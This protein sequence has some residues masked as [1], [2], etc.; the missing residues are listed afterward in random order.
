MKKKN[1]IKKDILIESIFMI[2]LVITMPLV[3]SALEPE[4]KGNEIKQNSIIDSISNFLK[5]IFSFFNLP[6]VS[7]EDIGC[8]KGT[9]SDPCRITT[10]HDCKFFN[11]IS[12]PNMPWLQEVFCD[13]HRPDN[14]CEPICCYDD[15]EGYC[16]QQVNRWVCLE[17]GRREVGPPD[18]SGVSLCTKGCCTFTSGLTEYDTESE[19][20]D[21]QGTWDPSVSEADCSIQGSIYNEGCC[22][23]GGLCT[24]TK[25]NE[26]PADFFHKD[27]FCSSLKQYCNCEKAQKKGCYDD[28]TDV[29]S[30]D[31][32]GNPED[33]APGG[34]CD[35]L[36]TGKKCINGA[37]SDGNCHVDLPNGTKDFT[38]KNGES[39]C[40]YDQKLSDVMED[41]MLDTKELS[42]GNFSLDAAGSR[43][44]RWYCENGEFHTEPCA[45]YRQEVCVQGTYE[46]TIN[47]ESY[48]LNEAQCVANPYDICFEKTT[49]SDCYA[50][51]ALGLCYWFEDV[52]EVSDLISNMRQEGLITA[53]I[54][55]EMKINYP[56]EKFAGF[57]TEE[58]DEEYIYPRCLPKYSPGY[59]QETKSPLCFLGSWA[60]A[61]DESRPGEF[62]LWTCG[63]NCEVGAYGIGHDDRWAVRE[64]DWLGLMTRRCSALGDCGLKVNIQGKATETN[65]RSTIE[66]IINKTTGLIA[67]RYVPVCTE[68]YEENKSCKTF[69][70]NKEVNLLKLYSGIADTSKT[71]DDDL[72]IVK[73][74][75][76]KFAN[77]VFSIEE[78]VK[79][80]KNNTIIYPIDKV[81]GEVPGTSNVIKN[82]MLAI[83]GF[84]FVIPGVVAFVPPTIF[85]V[86]LYGG[87]S[88]AT[89]TGGIH[90]AGTF[91][92]AATA[93][94]IGI[95]V[96]MIVA[97]LL[98]K[99]FP[100][101]GK[102]W[103]QRIGNLAGP[104]GGIGAYVLMGGTFL[105]LSTLGIGIAIFV[106]LFLIFQFFSKET[107]NIGYE[108]Q[109]LPYEP[110]AGGQDCDECNKDPSRPCSKYR[111]SSLGA[112]CNFTCEQENK[113]GECAQGQCYWANEGD[114][115]SPKIISV[116]S[117][118]NDVTIGDFRP[119]PPGGGANVSKP[120]GDCIDP[121]ETIVLNVTTNEKAQCK[122]D[123]IA[124][125][126]YD[127]MRWTF[128]DDPLNSPKHTI[129]HILSLQLTQMTP[130]F[131]AHIRCKDL[132]GNKN[133]G[134]EFKITFCSSTTDFAAPEIMWFD[135]N[136]DSN[137]AN[138]KT[139]VNVTLATNEP[140]EGCKW[141]IEQYLTYN[142]MHNNLTCSQ[143]G[144][145]LGS[146]CNT[147]LPFDGTKINNYYFK[148]NDTSGNAA[149]TDTSYVLNP[150]E[151]LTI[152]KISPEDTIGGCEIS[153]KFN[154]TLETSDGCC[155]GNAECFYQNN[156]FW[157][158][159][160]ETGYT[161]HNQEIEVPAGITN[162]IYNVACIDRDNNDANLTINLNI[163]KDNSIPKVVRVYKQG[164]QLVLQ[165]N[166]SATCVY[167]NNGNTCNFNATYFR[168]IKTFSTSDGI[169]HGT[170]WPSTTIYVRCYDECQNGNKLEPD[171]CTI[172][173]PQNVD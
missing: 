18:C 114:V 136:S 119:G 62:G 94:A 30:I 161:L 41:P 26:C 146:R 45:D 106:I 95:A 105:S 89:T 59:D 17:N 171:G 137:I 12:T 135:P 110:P 149:L 104:L 86:F 66:E 14:F 75:K 103:A 140:V 48:K 88:T 63:N 163:E 3:I 127:S 80:F 125:L 148:C 165:T 58:N 100:E 159:F 64:N 169:V 61:I 123:Y 37:C 36:R 54:P 126:D 151:P 35:Y 4:I 13:E 85:M 139:S 116:K 49:K 78:F 131:I 156:T 138:T 60:G 53:E 25:E 112:S 44:W 168:D 7:A 32:C 43:H 33:I 47:G 166:E 70:K 24:W 124:T 11:D 19:C 72:D 98:Y 144:T 102:Q 154:L 65:L 56:L 40:V 55:E 27:T 172:I 155:D 2:V 152:T 118:T 87:P 42:L 143:Q 8:C 57:T 134:E 16:A 141:S 130:Q 121:Y 157:E 117:L 128:S 147:I 52:P 99:F 91:S 5:K 150:V 113:D 173:V 10:E 73:E 164:T 77:D 39:I 170:P 162:T 9:L 20:T 29:Y 109:C 83:A 133:E 96:G 38:I 158:R 108:F 82:T 122:Y 6:G 115:V 15:N 132:N 67:Q 50:K 23:Y 79:E 22:T 69:D 107:R 28:K 51:D 34:N 81:S 142:A 21:L 76:N 84:I 167:K 153:R 1:K 129:G 145:G 68:Y 92:G 31:S 111:C 97:W 160:S 74:M 120:D 46:A 71:D 93:V 101:M 90:A